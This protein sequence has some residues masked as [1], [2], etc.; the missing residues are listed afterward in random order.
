[1]NGFVIAF[2]VVGIV[3]ACLAVLLFGA[4]AISFYVTVAVRSF[5]YNLG[6]Y[7][8]VQKEHIE[9]KSAARKARLAKTREQK[10]KQKE[11][12]L[13][14][15]LASQQR[16]FEMK[17]KAQEIK[18]KESEAKVATSLGMDILP[19]EEISVQIEDK[20]EKKEKDKEI[21]E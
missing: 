10:L 14:S 3:V 8:K 20:K 17:K 11:E 9:A 19:A 16:V 21:E 12:L 13:D 2:A 18:Q 15:K 4:W 1:M 7:C 5:K 6:E